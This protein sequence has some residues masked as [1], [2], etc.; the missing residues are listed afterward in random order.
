MS[1]YGERQWFVFTFGCGQ[2]HAGKY[3]RFFGDYMEARR[4]MCE[5]YGP[6]WAFQYSESDWKR[7]EER[8][9]KEGWHVET[10]WP[11]GGEQDEQ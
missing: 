11:E 9:A 7:V 6:V 1:E 10:Y 5:R 8:A 2:E 3:V 4:K